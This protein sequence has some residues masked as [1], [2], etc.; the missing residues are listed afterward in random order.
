MTE[1]EKK[2]MLIIASALECMDVGEKL[3]LLGKVEGM[4]NEKELA[5]MLYD[6]MAAEISS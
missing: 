4:A 1:K 6:L 3:Y 2:A 5:Q